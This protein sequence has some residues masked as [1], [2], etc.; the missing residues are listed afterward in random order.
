MKKN[1]LLPILLILLFT[2]SCRIFM[3]DEY[4]F[5]QNNLRKA[6]D[7]FQNENNAK[8]NL[9]EIEISSSK[10]IFN[11]GTKKFLYSK[12]YLREERFES[13]SSQK[14]F[15]LNEADLSNLDA[16]M[17][18][19]L[20]EAKKNSY[21]D[22][23]NI[24]Q[25]ILNKQSVNR[26]DNLVS[27]IDKRRDVMRFDISVTDTKITTKYSTNLKGEI[28]DVAETNIK[29]RLKFFDTD[30]MNKSMAEIKPLFG[31]KISISDF[32][33]QTENFS[34]TANDPNNP[35]ELNIYRYN[36]HE[37]LQA[38]SSPF[39]KTIEA[40][41]REEQMRRDG[42]PEEIIKMHSLD[43]NFFD[44]E[45]IN[46]SLIPQVM[47]KSL[48]ATQSSNAKVSSIVIRKRKD[49]YT[50]AATLEWWVETYGDR[51]EKETFVFDDKG[52]LNN[53][54]TR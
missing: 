45:E 15:L 3:R 34:F 54:Q 53:T 30:Q 9:V 49:P 47:S 11:T 5:D 22:K 36:S 52:I 29:P 39:Q 10:V 19:A 32:T 28:V 35:D 42:T 27:N 24:S 13:P 38:N 20:N 12:G 37:F 6:F 41:K 33:I 26:D 48:E 2:F 23:P 51:L 25:V 18:A 16:A 8:G 43:P 7:A 31:N 1:L 46:F 4:M 50:K 14:D 40:K 17:S 21:L 44:I